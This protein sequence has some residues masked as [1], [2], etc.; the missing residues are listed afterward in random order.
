MYPHLPPATMWAY[1]ELFARPSTK[2]LEAGRLLHKA[3]C[4]DSTAKCLV[5][6]RETLVLEQLDRYLPSILGIDA[7]QRIVL[8][9]G[10]ALQ[11]RRNDQLR[12][13]EPNGPWLC[14][15]SPLVCGVGVNLHAAN[16]ILLMEP[17]EVEAEE[18]QVIA[19]L[20]R[21]GQQKQVH[22][23]QLFVRGSVEERILQLRKEL[24]QEAAF[25]FGG[26]MSPIGA[27]PEQDKFIFGLEDIRRHL[28]EECIV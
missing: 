1:S 5:F 18:T 12:F 19:R 24:P 23:T 25:G 13:Q 27:C 11:A 8:H 21:M 2:I 9:G 26:T 22:V 10:M 16:H 15:C 14:L 6:S 20:L 17:F 4:A 28:E 3:R 7:S